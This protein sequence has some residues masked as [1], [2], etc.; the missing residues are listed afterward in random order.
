MPLTF[1]KKQAKR[2]K[3]FVA[4]NPREE[5]PEAKEFKP[6]HG[7]SLRCSR[8]YTW[9]NEWFFSGK[10]EVCNVCR[11]E[12]RRMLR[13]RDGKKCLSCKEKLPLSS[14]RSQQGTE[15][16]LSVICGVCSASQDQK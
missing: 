6:P 11:M 12:I 5:S 7:K 9:R 13:N 8:C 4:N 15:D 3:D 16:L 10:V 1:T 14:F 2:F